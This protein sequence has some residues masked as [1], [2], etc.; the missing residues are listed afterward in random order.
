MAL[1]RKS[2]PKVVPAVTDED[3]MTSRRIVRQPKKKNP[4]AALVSKVKRRVK[5]KS[6]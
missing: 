1:R 5:R 6:R 2:D 4:A 3:P